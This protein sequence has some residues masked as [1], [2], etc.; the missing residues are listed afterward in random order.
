MLRLKV[1][2]II[3]FFQQSLLGQIAP[4]DSAVKS[5]QL[6]EVCISDNSD[7]SDQAF[8]FYK[9]NKLAST[10]DILSRMQGVNLIK[11]G[12]FGLEPTLRNYSTG[13]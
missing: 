6:E 11:R 13:Q 4:K 9:T 5:I 3:I 8:N 1:I 10:E 12:A 2:T 7:N